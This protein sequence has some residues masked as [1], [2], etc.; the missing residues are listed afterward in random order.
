MHRMMVEAVKRGGGGLGLTQPR[1]RGIHGLH[2]DAVNLAE[3]KVL[4]R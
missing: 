3:H 4:W 1:G 2:R